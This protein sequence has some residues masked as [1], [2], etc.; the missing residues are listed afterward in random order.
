MKNNYRKHLKEYCEACGHN[1]SFYPL[2]PD[3][4]KTKGS[5]GSDEAYNIMTLCRK[6]H[7]EKGNKGTSHMAETYPNY[8]KWLL[9]NGWVFNNFLNKW[10]IN[11]V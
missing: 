1:G 10:I 6:H 8:K 4:V 3:H 5:G 7:V 11:K 2:D 9:D